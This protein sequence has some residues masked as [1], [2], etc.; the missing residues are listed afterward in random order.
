M[1]KIYI[2]NTFFAQRI[3]AKWVWNSELILYIMNFLKISGNLI[4]S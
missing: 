4:Y 2:L 1:Q 3:E